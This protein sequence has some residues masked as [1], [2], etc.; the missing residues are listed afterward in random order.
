MTPV[1]TRSVIGTASTE[2]K[3]A[4]A[5][6]LGADVTINYHQEGDWPGQVLAATG[7]RGADII[8]ESMGGDIFAKSFEA[9]A[10]FGHLVSFGA[11]SAATATPNVMNLYGPNHI[12]SG[13]LLSGWF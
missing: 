11:A 1:G 6:S 9:L 4:V 7:G 12:L 8:L 10:P 5:R 3:L 13:F 2:D